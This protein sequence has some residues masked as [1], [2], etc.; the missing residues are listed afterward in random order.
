MSVETLLGRLGDIRTPAYVLDEANL[1]RN[2]GTAARIREGAEVK[3]VLATKAFAL[4]QA[5]PLMKPYL[6]GT[7]ASGIYEARLG[8]EEF[9]KE[10]HVYSPAFDDKEIE[11]LLP[12]ASHISFNSAGQF[13]RY[14]PLIK[15]K[16]PKISIGM[17][18]NPELP[19]VE[20]AGFDKYN[21]CAP[22][23]R[24]GSVRA[25]ID[26]MLLQQLEGLHFHILCENMAADSV[27]LIDCVTE[28][29]GG[30]LNKVKWINFGGGHFIN[31][32]DYDVDRLIKRLIAFRKDFPHLEVIMEPGGGL[33]YDTG[34][35]VSTVL[36]VTSNGQQIAILDTSASTHMPD[37]L[38]VP[39]RPRVYGSGETGKK[40][41]DYILGGRTCMTADVIGSYSFD[42]PLKVGD[43]LVFTEM[44]QYSFVKNTQ[45]NGVPLPD[46]A[47]LHQDGSYEV[48]QSF[49]YADFKHRL[50]HIG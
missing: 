35:L 45:F 33:V 48:W 28:Q 31:H 30:W 9:G 29:F 5:F 8:H 1:L 18:I 43:K 2:L 42:R 41:H 21:P 22:C 17:R 11:D 4:F 12:I 23:S 25:H 26:E 3:V 20:K 34:Y 24:M 27:R 50:G 7:T 36:D 44:M 19:L 6:D 39:Y 37:V 13:R 46:L 10:V 16:N 14:G 32:P 47:V 38:E 49:G 15:Q 40:L